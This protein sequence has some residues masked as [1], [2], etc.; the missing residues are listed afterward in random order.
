MDSKEKGKLLEEGL[1]SNIIRAFYD[2]ANKYGSGLK[3]I[4]YQ[5]ALV[6]ILEKMGLKTE[7]QKR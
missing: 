6:E 4:V 1:C 5:K 2:V 7:Q 3:E